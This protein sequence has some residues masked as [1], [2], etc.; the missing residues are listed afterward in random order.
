MLPAVRH[1]RI[2][3]ILEQNVSATTGQ[4]ID[5]L[6]I[7]AMMLWR[8]LKTLD[9]QGLV[10]RVRGGAIK[11][12]TRDEPRFDNK[13]E[14]ARHA[15]QIIAELAQEHFIQDRDTIAL[16]GG[17]TVSALVQ[18]L[19]REQVTALTNSILILNQARN[20]TPSITTY[21][22]GGLLRET[23]GTLVG[24]EAVSFFS[25]RNLKTFFLSGTALDLTA[26]LTDPNPLEIEVKQAMARSAE[27][28]V[29]LLDSSKLEQRSL[30]KVMPLSRI[31]YFVTDRPLPP[32]YQKAFQQYK[33]N[34]IH[35]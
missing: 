26:G 21:S 6:G 9:E 32:S 33:V 5:E 14:A 27:R 31:D 35:P 3:E 10:K 15:K 1:R 23:S 16:E 28:V 12:G 18:C 29:L 25:R 17:T 24:K 8:D 19:T 4:L 11:A 22:S 30:M 7:N 20:H 2:L 34:T 13:I